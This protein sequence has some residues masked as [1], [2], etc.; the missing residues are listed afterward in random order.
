MISFSCG[1]YGHRKEVCPHSV[2]KE[3]MKDE[4]PPKTTVI[5]NQKQTK[6]TPAPTASPAPSNSAKSDPAKETFGPWMLVTRNPRSRGS[7]NE[8][9]SRTDMSQGGQ[10]SSFTNKESQP[11]TSRFSVL[12]SLNEEATQSP[13]N[14]LSIFFTP[15]K[16]ASH[17][18][19]TDSRKAD[20]GKAKVGGQK[21]IFRRKEVTGTDAVEKEN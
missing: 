17:F 12:A 7:R 10:K 19:K 4:S 21:E 14:D 8:V 20:K 3:K 11:G 13:S 2:M 9:S 1:R 5:E 15:D 16:H 6:P 18:A